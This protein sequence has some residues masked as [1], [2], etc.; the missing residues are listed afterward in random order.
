MGL[1][2]GES[3]EED[4]E[5]VQQQLQKSGVGGGAATGLPPPH[6]HHS[7]GPGATF[8]SARTFPHTSPAMSHGTSHPAAS[9]AAE[10]AAVVQSLQHGLHRLQVQRL[11]S[12]VLPA[13]EPSESPRDESLHFCAPSSFNPNACSRRQSNGVGAMC[14]T[15]APPWRSNKCRRTRNCSMHSRLW[16]RIGRPLHRH[17]RSTHRCRRCART[18]PTPATCCRWGLPSHHRFYTPHLHSSPT[19]QRPSHSVQT[20]IHAASMLHPC[21]IHAA[22]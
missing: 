14:R 7:G 13:I 20:R 9:A 2:G 4:E 18:L 22:R 21:R 6:H 11:L 5:W 1:Q 17:P 3:E 8:S 12:V 10:G 15:S 16:S 19:C